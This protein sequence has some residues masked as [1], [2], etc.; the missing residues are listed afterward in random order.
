MASRRGPRSSRGVC[1]DPWKQTWRS[2]RK[3]LRPSPDLSSAVFAQCV[4]RAAGQR[5]VGCEKPDGGL[6][7]AETDVGQQRHRA[8]ETLDDLAT[9]DAI[10]GDSLVMAVADGNEFALANPLAH[11]IGRDLQLVGRFAHR[12]P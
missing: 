5:V 1:G 12:K 10:G 2:E 11:L 6:D 9:V 7:I 3:G 4:D 8:A